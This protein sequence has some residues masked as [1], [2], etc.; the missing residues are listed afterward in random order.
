MAVDVVVTDTGA[1]TDVLAGTDLETCP[2]P[3]VLQI[4]AAS[5]V[6][7]ATATVLIGGK[8]AQRGAALL[9]RSNG[10]PSLA[11]DAPLVEVAVTGGEKNVVSLGGTTG[12]VYTH[13]R[14]TPLDELE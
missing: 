5:T 1:D 2:G 14:F 3:G 11:D 12:T 9:L 8:S 6:N 7:T 13:A 10:V 4:W